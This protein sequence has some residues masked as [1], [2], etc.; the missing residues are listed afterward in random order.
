M[1]PVFGTDQVVLFG[2][3]RD[4][5]YS[6]TWLYDISDN[7]WELQSPD[8]SPRPRTGH[9][10]VSIYGDDKV[11]LFGGTDDEI[12]YDDTWV[13]DLSD[14]LWTK[15]PQSVKPLGRSN[16]GMA[17]IC[18]D[19]KA[20]IF[21][22]SNA[23]KDLVDTWVYHNA[24]YSQTGVFTSAPF[25]AGRATPF[26][27]ISW[28]T[29]LTSNTTIKIQLR[30]AA[31]K[32]ELDSEAFVGPDGNEYTYYTSSPS[33]I[34]SEHNNDRWVQYKV[35]LRTTDEDETPKLKDVTISYNVRP[36]PPTLTGP[37]NDTW[38]IENKPKFTWEY[39]GSQSSLPGGF[40]LQLDDK[41]D[42]TSIDYDSTTITSGTNSYTHPDPISDRIWYWRLRTKDYD[43]FWGPYN[44]YSILKIDTTIFSPLTVKVTPSH[45]SSKNEFTIDWT[46]PDDLSGIKKG[47]FYLISDTPP[48]S[49]AD[50]TWTDEKPFK[51]TNA[52]EG[53]NTIHIWLIDNAGNLNYENCTSATFKLD[54]KSPVISHKPVTKGDPGKKILINAEIT[55]K[56]SGVDQ[57]YLYYKKSKD[58]K[59]SYIQMD[60]IGKNFSAVIPGNVVTTDGLGYF[61][62]VTDKAS[63]NNFAYYSKGG[64]AKNEPTTQTDFDISIS[65]KEEG[66]SNTYLLIGGVA[67][68]II[69]IIIIVSFYIFKNKKPRTSSRTLDYSG[70][71]MDDRTPMPPMQPQEQYRPPQRSP[72]TY[73]TQPTMQP[74]PQ[75]MP[76]MPPPMPP[77][78]PKVLVVYNC[79]ACEATLTDP[80]NCPYCGWS[81]E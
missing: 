61:I 51:F 70:E 20:V 30:S 79:E 1:A 41:S 45:W 15:R 44:E 28:N 55:D 52:A 64:L 26:G 39:N 25:D 53:I 49:Q 29:T 46:I 66:I 14:N 9:T 23:S 69:I 80:N 72:V 47:A 58:I 35:Q 22:G 27:T 7:S 65:K 73:Q 10:M 17:A 40:Q 33:K 4:R 16:H 68:V 63:P 31:L 34:W 38:L 48:I 37:A 19:D 76:P 54:T 43:G 21:G 75:P 60:K 32:T 13:Y 6:D 74:A 57:A 18:E 81:R 3:F 50:G 67:V 56:Y 8:T 2:G 11:V 42:F 5:T 62:K 78:Q 59:Y 36:G 71:T 12:Y 77:A 24:V